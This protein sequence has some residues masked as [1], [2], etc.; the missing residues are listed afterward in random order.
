MVLPSFQTFEGLSLVLGLLQFKSCYY[1]RAG[2][3]EL[4]ANAVETC[5]AEARPLG[6]SAKANLTGEKTKFF[7]MLIKTAP[8]MN[9]QN[10]YLAKRKIIVDAMKKK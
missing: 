8:M 1:L 5:N 7:M 6:A 2:T 9:I 3:I 10:K 4:L